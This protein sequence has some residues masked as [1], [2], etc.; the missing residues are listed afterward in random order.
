MDARWL[1]ASDVEQRVSVRRRDDYERQKEDAL[2][3]STTS[4]GVG[5]STAPSPP[6]GPRLALLLLRG[7][8][9]RSWRR[10]GREG[11]STWRPDMLSSICGGRVR[12]G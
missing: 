12:Q 11:G 10:P 7:S 6:L 9:D 2:L 3:R 5:S 8:T 1:T 4:L